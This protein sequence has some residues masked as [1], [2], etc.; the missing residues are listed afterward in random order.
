MDIHLHK[1]EL[2]IYILAENRRYTLKG[3][4]GGGNFLRS[5]RTFLN[6]GVVYSTSYRIDET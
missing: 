2:L 1:H 4:Q 3:I 6:V 5:H